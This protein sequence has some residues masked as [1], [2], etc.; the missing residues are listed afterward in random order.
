M[1]I[2]AFLAR[3]TSR[4]F[5]FWPKLSKK[6]KKKKSGNFLTKKSKNMNHGIPYFIEMFISFD[7]V[8][9]SWRTSRIGLIVGNLIR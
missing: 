6:K 7:Y 4:I 1:F 2:F 3:K 5:I 9:K 8:M